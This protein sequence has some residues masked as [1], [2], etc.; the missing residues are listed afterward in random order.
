MAS[1][2]ILIVCLGLR[3]HRLVRRF[4]TVQVNE[5]YDAFEEYE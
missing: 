2:A 1:A 4:I 3:L 5:S